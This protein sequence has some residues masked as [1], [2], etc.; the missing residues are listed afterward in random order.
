MMEGIPYECDAEVVRPDGSHRWIVARGETGRT[1]DGNIINLHGTVQDI[2]ERKQAETTLLDRKSKLDAIVDYSPSALSLK[3]TDGRYALANP[4]LQ[5]IHHLTEEE[6]IGKS[7]FDLYP[8]HIA[9]AFKAND[10]MVLS[11]LARHVVE[12][13]IPVDGK[14]RI[15]MSAYIPDT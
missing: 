13:L 5:R 7:D 4:N 11:T 10:A 15:Y 2:T 6:I 14:T 9:R 8:E 3:Y 12:E 1:A